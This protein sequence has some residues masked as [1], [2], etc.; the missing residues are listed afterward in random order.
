M[1]ETIDL[2]QLWRLAL[3]ALAVAA[4]AIALSF[5]PALD[6]T[7][8]GSDTLVGAQDEE[9]DAEEDAD[10]EEME[11]TDEEAETTDDSEEMEETD[12]GTAP[13]GGAETGAGGLAGTDSSNTLVPVAILGGTALLAGGLLT[14]S[15]RTA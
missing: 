5:T 3:V 8:L 14:A 13:E 15:R 11:E 4:T 2:R 6:A 7:P 9:E 12:E 10:A 1:T